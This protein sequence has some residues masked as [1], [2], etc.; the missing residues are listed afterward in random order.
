MCSCF[1]GRPDFH[2]EEAEDASGSG[3]DTSDEDSDDLSPSQAHRGESP[4]ILL[5][6]ANSYK[7]RDSR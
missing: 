4:V 5:G 3:V 2:D 7:L 6:K 1:V